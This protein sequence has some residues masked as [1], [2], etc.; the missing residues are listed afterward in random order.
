MN[1]MPWVQLPVHALAL[2]MAALAVAMASEPAVAQ[3]TD[4]VILSNG[5]AVTGEV[6]EFQRGKMKFSTDAMGTVY[7]EWPKIVTLTTDKTFEIELEDGTTFFGSMSAARASMWSA[8]A[9]SIAF[10]A[11]AVIPRRSSTPASARPTRKSPK[12]SKPASAGSTSSPK[13]RWRT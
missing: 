1:K 8:A 4:V 9:R 10:C 7:V 11:S 6:K 13:P 5:N 3:K 2:A 12:R